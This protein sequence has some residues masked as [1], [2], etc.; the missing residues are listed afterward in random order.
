MTALTLGELVDTLVAAR[1]AGGF[2]Y[3]S[4]E[5]VL[6]QFA[7]HSRRDG[8][9]DGS[10]IQEAVEEFLYGRHSKRPPSAARRSSFA[11][12]QNTPASSAG[13]HGRRQR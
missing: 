10:I 13:K 4:Q 2:R 9:T 11:N 6:R 12:W 8:Y 3:D 7:E 1:R 5:R